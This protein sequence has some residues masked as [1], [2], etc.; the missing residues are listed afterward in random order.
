M[1][2]ISKQVCVQGKDIPGTVYYIPDFVTPD[3]ESYL[4]RKIQ[5]VPKT[6]WKNL[7]RRRLQTYGG[8]I[9]KPSNVLLPSPLPAFLTHFPD[10]VSRIEAIGVFTNS[11]HGKPNHVL[12]NEYEPGQGIMP[13]E[14]GPSY[15]PTVATISL[16]SHTV[17]HYYRYVDISSGPSEPPSGSAE[18]ETLS[19]AGTMENQVNEGH[20][21]RSI[22]PSPVLS[23]LLEPRSLVITT[24][25]LY[26]EHLHGISEI[27]VDKFPPH[28]Q[29]PPPEVALADD[30]ATPE[31]RDAM[32]VFVA[33]WSM[34]GSSDLKQ[35]LGEGGSLSRSTRVSLTF[36]DVEKVMTGASKQLGHLP[37]GRV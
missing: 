3:E 12:V 18:I 19:Q 5:E 2:L 23:L 24:K 34:L 22:D 20:R 21:G 36:R 30:V 14:D 15:Y 16:G 8:E 31:T 29:T 7:S 10:L 17:V 27:E 33:N 35:R 1:D 32:P 9:A 37:F 13:H 6:A 4:L 11:K 26:T 28:G 25:E